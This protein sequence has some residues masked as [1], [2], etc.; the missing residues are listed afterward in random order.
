MNTLHA[1][2]LQ[3]GDTIGIVSPSSPVLESALE[4]GIS[5]LKTLGFKIK[6]SEHVFSSERFLAGKDAER[7]GDIMECFINPDIKA[8]IA[9]RG[10]QGSQRILPFLDY[11]LIQKNPKPLFGFSDTTALQLGLFKKTGLVSYTGYTLTSHFDNLVK[12]TLSSA[13]F[14]KTYNISKGETVKGGNCKGILLGGNLTLL[15]NLMGTPYFPCFKDSIL[16]L[17]DVGVTPYN[18]DGMLSQLA[19]AG[20][21]D[22]VSG[23][24]FGMFEDC[25]SPTSQQSDGSVQDV[26]SEWSSQLKIPCIKEFP[27][28]H[29]NHNSVLPIG[30]LAH[31]DADNPSV[32]I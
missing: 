19:L 8:I 7:A 1:K 14:G 21:F 26:I 22:E 30:Q 3:L 28:G 27:Y 12:T 16:L 24:I 20:I 4:D 25:G 5:F 17:E 29:G 15:T 9:T 18:I 11:D 23:V 2:P 31:L 6:L 32:L 13:M 10:G